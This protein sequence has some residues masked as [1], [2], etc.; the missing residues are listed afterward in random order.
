MPL[1]DIA[2]EAVGGVL[3]VAGRILFE[4]IVELAIKGMGH[5]LIRILRPKS[6]PGEM[7]CALVGLLFWALLITVGI[8]VH[9]RTV[10]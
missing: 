5:V 4:L 3:R 6:E 10:A 2:G 1:G 8:V 7:A 9:Q